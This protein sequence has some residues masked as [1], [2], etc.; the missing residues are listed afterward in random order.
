G[1]ASTY[2]APHSTVALRNVNAPGHASWYS[3]TG[4]FIASYDIDQYN[5][6]VIAPSVTG[7]FLLE[8]VSG[9]ERHTYKILISE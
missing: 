3:V 7:V 1:P 5:S 2:I 8:V 4:Q 9:S 6:E